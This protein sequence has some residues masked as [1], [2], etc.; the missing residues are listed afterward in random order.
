MAIVSGGASGIGRATCSRFVGEGA[1]VVLAD[2][3]ERGGKAAIAEVGESRTL[4]E[5]L[6]VRNPASWQ[7]VVRTAVERFSRLDILVNSAGIIRQGTIEDTSYEAWRQ[8]L[9]V[10]VDGTFL[11]CQTAIKEMKKFGGGSI[12]NISSTSA[13]VADSDLLAYD[14]SKGAIRALTKEIAAY[15][16][17]MRLGIR[18]NSVHPGTVDTPMVSK[19]FEDPNSAGPG[20]WI[21]PHGI[22]RLARANEV[23]GLI[24]FL[25]SDDAS[26]ATGGEFTIDGAATAASNLGVSQ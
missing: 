12:I 17:A 13:F 15:C 26:F 19:F 9:A 10:N 18:C 14:A 2:I 25:A 3:D 8:T 1:F 11:G 5:Q 4:F 23:A 6:D 20:A 22:K 7:K 24:A 16:A 21:A